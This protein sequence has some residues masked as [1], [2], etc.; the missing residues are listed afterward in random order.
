MVE[1]NKRYKHFK[2]TE[3]VPLFFAKDSETL[4]N[5]V[6]YQ[7]PENYEIWARPEKMWDD[8]IDD[9]GTKRFTLVEG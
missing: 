4:E 1:L 6:I 5:L 9:N 3:Y 7:N 2:G 8:V